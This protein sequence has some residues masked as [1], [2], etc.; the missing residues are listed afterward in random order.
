MRR[1]F[2]LI[3]PYC[4]LV[5]L[6]WAVIPSV[7]AQVP[8]LSPG[9]H[10]PAFGQDG[11]VELGIEAE[12]EKIIPDGN[13]II[14]AGSMRT[15]NPA[16]RDFFIGKVNEEGRF[17][18]AFGDLGTGL[19]RVDCDVGWDIVYSAHRTGDGGFILMG[20]CQLAGGP[21]Y[22]A[23]AKFT[24]DGMPDTSFGHN[25]TGLVTL[26]DD[27]RYTVG[28]LDEDQNFVLAGSS[29]T[30]GQPDSDIVFARVDLAGLPDPNL[31]C[32]R[33]DI[34][35]REFDTPVQLESLNYGH[36]FLLMGKLR[37]SGFISRYN[38][39]GAVD[40]SF[41]PAG[42]MNAVFNQMA[43]QQD[44]KIVVVGMVEGDFLVV[45]YTSDGKLD[46]TFRNNGMWRVD[47]GG[48]EEAT[49]VTLDNKGRILIAGKDNKG[50]F[51]VR[52]LPKYGRRDPDFGRR[53]VTRSN[54]VS[55]VSA[56]AVL[57]NGHCGPPWTVFEL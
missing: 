42:V 1:F 56:M 5:M 27:T 28:D 12:V 19:S 24:R 46:Q 49:A 39:D 23:L 37:N 52:L 54:I 33:H 44:G 53:G 38:R 18:P 10:D 13:N 22:M 9:D 16:D 4:F 20:E 29:D 36:K 31:P 26:C 30:Y 25:Q 50:H 41:G 3:F 7:R 34:G 17:D 51:V 40:S 15:D 55:R 45:R 48:T 2:D 8:T 6:G 32:K 47:K 11:V 43:V 21:F 57:I 14:V 35:W